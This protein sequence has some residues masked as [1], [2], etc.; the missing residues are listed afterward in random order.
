M[1]EGQEMCAHCF[2]EV[3]PSEARTARYSL[4]HLTSDQRVCMMDMM[5][6]GEVPALLCASCLLPIL[7]MVNQSLGHTPV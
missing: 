3:E 2:A 5:S 6:W 7:S 4:E 1:H